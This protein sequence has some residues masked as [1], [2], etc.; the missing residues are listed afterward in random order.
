LFVTSTLLFALLQV[1]PNPHA[2]ALPGVPDEL[3]NRPE[4]KT[5]SDNFNNATSAWLAECLA[6]LA[7]DPA[8]A[9]ATAQ[10]RRNDTTAADRIVANHCLGLA[11]TELGLW[12]DAITAFSAAR[13]ETPPDELRARS[14]FGSMAGNAA[15]AGGEAPRALIILEMAQQDA[16]GSAS[17]TLEAL[18]AI[19]TARALVGMD[20]PERA[21]L[22]LETATQIEPGK[23]EGWLLMATLLRREGRLEEAQA[24]IERAAQ[25][26]P[27]DAQIGLE[28]GVIAV[29]SGRS[30][31]ARQSWQSVID[32]QPDSLAAATAADYLA[33]LGPDSP[34]E[35]E[36]QSQA[37]PS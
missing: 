15:L 23:G 31:A 14:R 13:D 29:L 2:G 33:Q 16:R 28:A 10:I 3:I 12:D 5:R 21:L 17:A 6:L 34:S 22:S 19:D 35:P 25:A 24:A 32:A 9:H 18:A 20:L 27:Q 30:D 1:G 7:D 36:P 4:R 26:A 11:A 37:E 8:R